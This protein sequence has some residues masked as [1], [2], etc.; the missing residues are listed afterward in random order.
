L[1]ALSFARYFHVLLENPEF[2][3]YVGAAVGSNYV[4]AQLSR[5]YGYTFP[6]VI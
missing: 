5:R 4:D 2:L 1:V 6:H 3:A